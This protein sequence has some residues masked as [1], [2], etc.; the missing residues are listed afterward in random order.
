MVMMGTTIKYVN[1]IAASMPTIVVGSR[2]ATLRLYRKR[3]VFGALTCSLGPLGPGSSCV[4][5][6]RPFVIDR[7]LS[8]RLHRRAYFGSACRFARL[9]GQCTNV[10]SRLIGAGRVVQGA[11]D[12]PHSAVWSK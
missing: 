4:F 12:P 1:R 9:G 10:R 2:S 8:I 3:L 5:S 7:I 6:R 11:Y